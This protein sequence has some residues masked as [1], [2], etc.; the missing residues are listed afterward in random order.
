VVTETQIADTEN[1]TTTPAIEAPEP[2]R[3]AI[4]SITTNEDAAA[5]HNVED[6]GMT[7]NFDDFKPFLCFVLF[8]FV[9]VYLLF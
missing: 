6:D 9:F 5:N 8:C 3:A 1:E 2:E 7:D 4:H